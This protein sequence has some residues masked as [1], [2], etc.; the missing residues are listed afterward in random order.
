MIKSLSKQEIIPQC[1][2]AMQHRRESIVTDLQ[3]MNSRLAAKKANL[4]AP[5]R[6][7]GGS[8]LDSRRRDIKR[9]MSA[10]LG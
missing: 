1:R 3:A 8:E 4:V 2:H 6:R 7:C 10:G 9:Q 5:G